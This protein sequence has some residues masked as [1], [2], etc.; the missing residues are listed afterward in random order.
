MSRL[1]KL[2]LTILQAQIG[3]LKKGTNALKIGKG[4][5]ALLISGKTPD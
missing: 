4:V 3:I 1:P 2:T 5:D